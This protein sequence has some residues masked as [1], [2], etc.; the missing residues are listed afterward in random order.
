MGTT[1]IP[2]R[3]IRRGVWTK[4]CLWVV[5]P[6]RLR[7]FEFTPRLT[8]VHEVRVV[9]NIRPVQSGQITTTVMSTLYGVKENRAI[10]EGSE[11]HQ[12]R[13]FV[14]G[15]D[16]KTIDW[17]RSARR[18]ALVAR[19]LQA[20]RNHHVILAFDTGYLMREDIMGLPKI[21]HATTAGLATAWAA[22]VG[23]R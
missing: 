23:D 19:E 4:T 15:M 1:V 12:L 9:P 22:A 20:E 7:L 18:R 16:V 8:V 6:S 5:W 17:K 10:G 13:D 11:F 3:A 2:C 21:D 14:R